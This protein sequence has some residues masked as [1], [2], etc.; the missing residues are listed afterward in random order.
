MHTAMRFFCVSPS[1]G[2]E[3]EE[4]LAGAAELT[5]IQPPPPRVA[6]CDEEAA[7]LLQATWPA[8]ELVK[9]KA[10]HAADALRLCAPRV[11]RGEFVDLALLDGHYLRRSDA[12]IFGERCRCPGGCGRI[13]GRVKAEI[14]IRRMTAGDLAGVMEIATGLPDAPH[15]PQSAYANALNPDSTPR[16]IA[17]VIVSAAADATPSALLGF[18]VASLLP[19]QAELETIAVTPASQ[20]RGLGRQLFLALAGELARGGRARPGARS[21]R[22]EPGGARILPFPGLRRNGPPAALLH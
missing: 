9:T 7:R 12:E 22:L 20:R 8:V 2:S 3:A 6:V 18:A 17:L 5:A 13:E 19:P 11:A 14:E 1:P 4:L 10:P 21:P 16:R 15:W